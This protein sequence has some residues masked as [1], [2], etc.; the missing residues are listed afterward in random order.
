[1]VIPDASI[2]SPKV[3]CAYPFDANTSAAACKMNARDASPFGVAG[4][5]ADA[6]GR[7]EVRDRDVTTP[8]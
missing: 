2:K 3:V 6:V 5:P 7:R 8:N 4:A 1:L